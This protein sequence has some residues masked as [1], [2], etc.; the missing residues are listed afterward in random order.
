MPRTHSSTKR[1]SEHY[2]ARLAC[3]ASYS[4]FKAQLNRIALNAVKVDFPLFKSNQR[5]QENKTPDMS[6]SPEI[7]VK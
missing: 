2:S 4:E 3:F 6:D 1:F 5:K 7:R